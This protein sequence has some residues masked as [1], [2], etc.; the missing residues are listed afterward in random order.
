SE[1]LISNLLTLREFPQSL[2]IADTSHRRP[3]DLWPLL[4]GHKPRISDDWL[5]H[6]SK[7]YSFQ[8]LH[9]EAWASICDQGTC[10]SF[11]THEWAFSSDPD[12]R[13]RV[14]ELLNRTL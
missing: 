10:D 6:E 12:R 7:V 11:Q 8:D 5:L 14:V 3:Q 13:R 1:R 2:W 9:S 4:D